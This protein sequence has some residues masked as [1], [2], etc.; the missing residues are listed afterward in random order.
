VQ[1]T[2]LAAVQMLQQL[3]SSLFI[4]AGVFDRTPT[5]CRHSTREQSEHH[6]HHHRCIP[7]RNVLENKTKHNLVNQH[8]KVMQNPKTMGNVVTC[9]KQ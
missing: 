8:Q 2:A 7:K 5:P 6:T 1:A 4:P 9:P 3:K